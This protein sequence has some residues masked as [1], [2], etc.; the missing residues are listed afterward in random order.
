DDL[1]PIRRYPQELD[2]LAA[3]ELRHGDHQPCAAGYQRQHPALVGDIRAR[4]R[5]RQ[6]QRGGVVDNDDVAPIGDWREVGGAVEERAATRLRWQYRLLPE[7]ARAV[8]Q[9]APG[10]QHAVT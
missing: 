4:I 5:L 6:S 1:D 7:V 9:P 8:R 2:Q 3:G 10:G